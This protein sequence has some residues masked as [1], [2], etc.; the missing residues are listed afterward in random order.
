MSGEET[1]G[2]VV[3]DSIDEVLDTFPSDK[4][5]VYLVEYYSVS[6]SGLHRNSVS[7]HTDLA[8]HKAFLDVN[9]VEYA[10][11]NPVMA[12]ASPEVISLMS[13]QSFGLYLSNKAGKQLEE[14]G[15]VYF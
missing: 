4:K 7:L 2:T 9:N 15:H 14:K 1:V 8:N 5:E 13:N 11:K 12:L 3:F 10:K 6:A